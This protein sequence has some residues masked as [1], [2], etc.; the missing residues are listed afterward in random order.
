[1]QNEEILGDFKPVEIWKEDY[2]GAVTNYTFNNIDSSKV[3]QY[4]L[5]FLLQMIQSTSGSSVY[6]E[7]NAVVNPFSLLWN[8]H[9]GGN[10]SSSQ[11]YGSNNPSSIII[12]SVNANIAKENSVNHGSIIFSI[13]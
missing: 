4:K 8:Y 2:T 6:L 7:P 1:M 9:A 5:D 11:A 3:L 12:N 13:S 10:G